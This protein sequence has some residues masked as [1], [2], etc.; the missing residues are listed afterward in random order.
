MSWTGFHILFH[1]NAGPVLPVWHFLCITWPTETCM[2]GCGWVV[3]DGKREKEKKDRDRDINCNTFHSKKKSCNKSLQ[4][5]CYLI[6]EMTIIYEC[7]SHSYILYNCF[8]S[9]FDCDSLPLSRISESDKKEIPVKAIYRHLFKASIT[10]NHNH[11]MPLSHDQP[12]NPL[13][14]IFTF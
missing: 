8:F 10:H 3:E 1:L 7:Q 14:Q 9:S 5:K 2:T 11:Q 13:P 6:T 4:W 12:T